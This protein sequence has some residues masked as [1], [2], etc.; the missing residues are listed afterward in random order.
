MPRIFQ[1]IIVLAIV[2]IFL[3]N[4]MI[5]CEGDPGSPG[6]NM[7]NDD[8]YPPTI[9]LILPV[10]RNEV[11]SR[12]WFEAFVRD[13]GDIDSVAFLVDG[14][15]TPLS[16]HLLTNPPW[17]LWWNAQALPLGRHYIQAK[18]WDHAGHSN[19][20]Q[21]VMF[22]L[23]DPADATTR[24]TVS[25]YDPASNGDIVW[26]LP[27]NEHNYTGFGSRITMDRAGVVRKAWVKV[28]RSPYWTGTELKF[29]I[30]ESDHGVP[31]ELLWESIL[32]GIN[33]LRLP[34][35]DSTGWARIPIFGN[36]R[37]PPEYFILGTLSP[38]ATGDT[39]AIL[40]DNGLYRGGHGVVL[41]DGEWVME[42]EGMGIFPNPLIRVMV[43]SLGCYIPEGY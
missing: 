7:L 32:D 30:R 15:A 40:T 43:D 11:F 24:D 34:E 28:K 14:S 35:G 6:I 13:D 31:G 8:L 41:I 3:L 37:L 21:R 22:Y 4:T 42:P 17:T 38:D 36:F 27:S 33:G 39:L 5:G 26:N 23:L 9:D 19:V 25:F 12:L 16:E 1:N 29:E 2:G 10:A 18:A 20:S